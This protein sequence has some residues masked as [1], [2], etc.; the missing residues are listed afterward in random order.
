MTTKARRQISR[1]EIQNKMDQGSKFKERKFKI[2]NS[3]FAIQYIKDLG[4]KFK[5]QSSRNVD[6]RFEIQDS[7]RK[8][9]SAMFLQLIII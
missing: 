1:T 2:R 7:E 4:S 5:V 8:G 9:S 6:S 3:K